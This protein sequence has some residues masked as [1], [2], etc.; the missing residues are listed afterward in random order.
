M[1]NIFILEEITVYVID[2]SQCA[3]FSPYFTGYF[4]SDLYPPRDDSLL[5]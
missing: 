1:I 5:L 2:F 4:L 3:N